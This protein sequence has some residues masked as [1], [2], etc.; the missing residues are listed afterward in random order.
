MPHPFPHRYEV[1][2]SWEAGREGLVT[3]PPRPPIAGGPPPE[4]DGRPELWSP[5]HLLLSA[6]NLCQMTTFLALA[7]KA[8]LEVVSYRSGASGVLDKTA[9]GLRFTAIRLR[10]ALRV[11][12]ADIERGRQLVHT[13]HKHCIVSNALKIGVEIE[14]AVTAPEDG[15]A[16][17]GSVAP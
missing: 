1:G 11:P 12:P 9:E 10:V 13:A 16:G 17:R 2:L 3:A 7:A 5:E 14:D 8:R 15:N 4:F 6:L